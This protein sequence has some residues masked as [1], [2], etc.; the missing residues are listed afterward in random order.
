M[1]QNPLLKRLTILDFLAVDLQLFLDTHPDDSE[2]INKYNSVIKEADMLRNQYEKTYGP[3]YSFRS[4]S[5]DEFTWID[6]PWPWQRE[7]NFKLSEE[8]DK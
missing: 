7:F 2:A 6:S 3:L 1:A 4:K 8:C 5:R